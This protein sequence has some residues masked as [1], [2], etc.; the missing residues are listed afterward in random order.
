[1]NQTAAR[2][3]PL[4][5]EFVLLAKSDIIASDAPRRIVLGAREGS[6]GTEFVTWM[7][8]EDDGSC[9][10]GH[11]DFPNLWEA[12]ADFHARVKRGY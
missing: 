6:R 4:P 8:R 11:Y 5:N 1:M 3:D 7:R 9:H 2:L 12:L 10:W